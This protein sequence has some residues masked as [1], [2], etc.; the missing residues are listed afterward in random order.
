MIFL[1]TARLVLRNWKPDDLGELFDYRN[2]DRCTRYQRGQHRERDALEALIKRRMQDDFLPEGKKQLA[3]A[4]REDDL[5]V[6]E[7]TIFTDT[8]SILMGYTIS[9]KHHR[10]GYAYEMLSAIIGELR[11]A[12]PDKDFLCLVQPENIASMG[13]LRKLGFTETG[14]DPEEQAVIFRKQ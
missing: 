14:F 4:R 6:G 11:N 3:I 9:C 13:L 7:V 1:Q 10:K 5:L 12:Y 8:P 2:D